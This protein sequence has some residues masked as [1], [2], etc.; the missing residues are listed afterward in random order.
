MELEKNM[1]RKQRVQQTNELKK[2]WMSPNQSGRSNF[3][4]E[5]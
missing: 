5:A 2:L 3:Q 1:K 4:S